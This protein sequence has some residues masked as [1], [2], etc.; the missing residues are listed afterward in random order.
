MIQKPLFHLGIALVNLGAV[1]AFEKEATTE[2]LAFFDKHVFPLMESRC[3]NCHGIDDKM[4]GD[5]RLT[6]REGLL[7]GGQLGPAFDVGNPEQ[8][9][10]L[11]MIAYHDDEHQMPPREKMSDEEIAVFHRWFETG[12]LYNPAKEIRGPLVARGQHVQPEDFEYWAYKPVERPNRKSIDEFI[13]AKL[14]ERS[15]PANRRA[16]RQT[17]VRRAYYDLTGLP[18]SPEDVERFVKDPRPHVVV[19]V[20]LIEMLLSR[21]QYGEK[22]GRHWLDLVRYAETNG[23]ERDN[24]KPEIWRYRDYVI[25][26]FNSDKPYDQFIIEQLAGDE[27]DQPTLES[28][29]ATG[30]YRLM[31]WD[32]EPADRKQHTYDVLADNVGVATE[33][34]LGST[35]GCAR[36]HDHKADPFTQKDFYSFM[37]FFHGITSYQT[38]GTMVSWAEPEALRQFEATKEERIR[39]LQSD[40]VRTED[41]L[42]VY[43]ENE[44]MLRRETLPKPKTF[45]ERAGGEAA[46]I[47][48]YTFSEPT[49]DW[50]DVGFRNKNWYKGKGGFG[51]NTP[52]SKTVTKWETPDIWIRTS[53]GLNKIP[54]SLSLE[55]YHDEAVEVFL[56]GVEIFRAK[57]YV[58]NYLEIVLDQ[59]ALDALQTGRNIVAVHCQNTG[60]GQQIDLALRTSPQASATLN[61]AIRK[62]GKKLT[63]ELKNALGDD[64]IA[65]RADLLTQIKK[66]RESNI[67][68]QLNAVMEHNPIAPLHVHMRGSAHVP[69]DQVEPAFPGVLTRNIDSTPAKIRPDFAERPSSGRRLALA[70][71]IASPE[72]PLTSR[73]M[74]NRVWQHHFGRGIVPTSSDFGKLGEK[75]THPELL[76]W[77]ASEFVANDWSLK[78][79]HRLIMTSE[80]YQRSSAPSEAAQYKDPLNQWFWRKDMRRLTAEEVRDSVLAVSGNL[81]LKMAGPWVYIPLPEE[82]LATSSRPG[83]NWPVSKGDEAFRRSIYVHVKRSLRV[84]LLVDHDQ[85]DTDGHCAVRF[86][87]TV[88]TQALGMLNSKFVNSQ[89]KILAQRCRDHSDILTKQI[90]WGLQLGSQRA[91][92]EH[93][94]E[95]LVKMAQHLSEEG[96]LTASEALDRV[97]LLILNLNEFVYLD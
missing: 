72:N 17:L 13:G 81:N 4:K 11:K 63:E 37:A 49:Q 9:L 93:E 50:K 24:P 48:E 31:Q 80:A 54:E 40:L 60:G 55:I 53:F 19:W 61:E 92:D 73:V 27:I 78:K 94:V 12:A 44:G 43:L 26:A 2:Q 3:L 87:T 36:C 29:S 23:F 86:A 41:Q 62:G 39:T 33:T 85:A 20:E 57:G 38:P 91:T 14:A 21:P 59:V 8:S 47:W 25:E 42:K 83:K 46:P 82:V 64:L 1:L 69:G 32:D 79:M 95:K 88:P 16:S 96:G 56:N 28:L 15:I 70:E 10:L 68:V 30:F 22:W 75:A 6:S 67:G 65:H 89:A 18:P 90:K 97:A 76:D 51:T 35:I 5:L 71:W 52:N 77:L 66:A 84:P 34:F 74:M 45:V 58:T 7:H